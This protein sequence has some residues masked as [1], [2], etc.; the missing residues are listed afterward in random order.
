MSPDTNLPEGGSRD[1]LQ[2]ASRISGGA[3]DQYSPQNQSRWR[4]KQRHNFL[5]CLKLTLLP[6]SDTELTE[7]PFLCLGLGVAFVN[8]KGGSVVNLTK[9]SD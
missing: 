7:S 3:Q 6:G 4:V 2:G 5:L 8:K 1:G 9:F